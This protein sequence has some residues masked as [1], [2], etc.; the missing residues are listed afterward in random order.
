VQTSGFAEGEEPMSDQNSH[1]LNEKL[2]RRAVLGGAAALVGGASLVSCTEDAPSNSF[3]I[4]PASR[5]KYDLIKAEGTHREL[6][7]QHGEQAAESIRMHLDHIASSQKLSRDALQ[8][9][10]LQFTELFHQHCPHLLDEIEGLAEGAGITV[11]DAMACNLR[12]ELG[13]AP[14]EGCT[15]YVIGK[16]ATADKE[17]IVGQNSDMSQPN[18]EMGYILH[19]KPQDKPQVLIWTFGGMIGYHG[20][21]SAGVA[22]FANALGG[23][24]A[25]QFGLS[26]YPVK[27]L[28]LECST[29]G[30]VLDIFHRV[31]LA[32]NGN[33][34]VCDGDGVI[35]DIEANSNGP[36]IV[37]DS[38]GGYI[39]HTNHYL[40]PL[41]GTRENYDKSVADSF[42]RLD[43]MNKM[44]EA[45]KGRVSVDRIKDYLSDHSNGDSSICRHPRSADLE[46][47]FETAGRTVASM[48]A[49]PAKNRMHVALG[50][51]CDSEYVTY[52]MDA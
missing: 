34:V 27:R 26:H 47:G 3:H 30:E 40:C 14:D 31:P 9:K 23:G 44:I 51:P 21:N 32:S 10:A 12:G 37:E 38:G 2:S 22:H 20:M 6:G 52:T 39:A 17:V 11:A 41:Y 45:D 49:E 16:N 7:R 4:E 35:L 46:K 19:L 42:P 8:A 5:T 1:N 48:I 33:Y 36:Q 43:Q 28:M 29:M 50:N 25:G 18:I 24:P 13:K 15:T